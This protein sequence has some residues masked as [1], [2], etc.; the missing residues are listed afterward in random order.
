MVAWLSKPK[1]LALLGVW[2]FA[3]IAATAGLAQA[4]VDTPQMLDKAKWEE[5]TKD[6]SYKPEEPPKKPDRK[7]WNFP[8]FWGIAS[9]DAFKYGLIA[10]VVLLIGYLIYKLVQPEWIG[11]RSRPHVKQPNQ[12]SAHTPDE[13]EPIYD[14]E[15]QLQQALAQNQYDAALRIYYLM[16]IKGLVDAGLIQWQKDKTNREYL[17]E[18]NGQP[19]FEPFKKATRTFEKVWYGTLTLD[20][21]Q[22]KNYQDQFTEVAEQLNMK[23]HAE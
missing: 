9:S 7:D 10:A 8:E 19:Q 18:L 12:Y 13:D 6:V 15:G 17:R 3:S 2:A 11:L 16:I 5:L 21:Q 1:M 20:Y 14:L 23:L 4:Q 22:F